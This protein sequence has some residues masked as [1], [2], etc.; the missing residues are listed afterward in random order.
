MG[1]AGFVASC[2][3]HIFFTL[4]D[5]RIIFTRP[6]GTETSEARCQIKVEAIPLRSAK[7]SQCIRSKSHLSAIR[8]AQMGGISLDLIEPL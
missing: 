4:C 2:I 3:E 1:R 8:K 5:N 6:A 7:S